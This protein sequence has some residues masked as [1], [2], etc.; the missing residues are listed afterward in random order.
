MV[1]S[2]VP[3]LPKKENLK[4][5]LESRQSSELTEEE[6][7]ILPQWAV[8]K[9]VEWRKLVSDGDPRPIFGCDWCGPKIRAGYE[10]PFLV[11]SKLCPTCKE[12]EKEGYYSKMTASGSKKTFCLGDKTVWWSNSDYLLGTT[13]KAENFYACVEV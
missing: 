9:T 11:Y 10:G 4:K 12:F 8:S 2:G 3:A 6:R 7:Q 13:D 5:Q 1:K